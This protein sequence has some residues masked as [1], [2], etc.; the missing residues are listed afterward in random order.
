MSYN[1]RSAVLRRKSRARHTRSREMEGAVERDELLW[2][3]RKKRRSREYKS[4]SGG[5]L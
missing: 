5:E 3:N 2:C 1:V 4:H